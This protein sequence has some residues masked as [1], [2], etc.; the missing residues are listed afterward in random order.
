MRARI[1]ALFLL[2][3][4]ATA[5]PATA[6]WFSYPSLGVNLNIGSAPNPTPAQL[7]QERSGPIAFTKKDKAFQTVGV[8]SPQSNQRNAIP[9]PREKP[10]PEPKPVP[11]WLIL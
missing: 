3:L 6:N 4:A 5:T 7:R 11:E 8:A 2:P 10:I 9:V 1:L